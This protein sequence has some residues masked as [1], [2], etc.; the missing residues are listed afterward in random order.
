MGERRAAQNAKSA[1]S[2]EALQRERE[3]LQ[4]DAA[5]GRRAKSISEGRYG[6]V[7]K[8]W[9]S[10]TVSP[11][12]ERLR[13][14]AKAQLDGDHSKAAELLSS[15][16]FGLAS[17]INPDIGPD[18][19]AMGSVLRWCAKGR[20]AGRGSTFADDLVLTCLSSVLM[21]TVDLASSRNGDREKARTIRT[22]VSAL[23][24]HAGGEMRE[25][26][27][28]QFISCFQGAAGIRELKI[29]G[30]GSGWQ[31]AKRVTNLANLLMSQVRPQ[32]EAAARGEIS[33]EEHGAR[34]VVMVQYS[35][36]T[37]KRRIEIT[38]PD[39]Y[40]WKLLSIARRVGSGRDSN[41]EVWSSF[42]LMILACAQAEAG[43]FDIVEAKDR[44][45]RK[46]G[47]KIKRLVLSEQAHR[48]VSADLVHWL[49]AGF[50]NEP[51][52]VPPVEGGYLTVKHRAVSSKPGPGGLKT[53]AEDTFAWKT[54]SE[55]IA[56]TAWSVPPLTLEFLRARPDVVERSEPDPLRRDAI[57][58]A[59]RRLAAEPNLYLPIFMDFRGRVYTR[60]SFV[61]YQGG[62]LQKGLLC[63]PENYN[64]PIPEPPHGGYSVHRPRAGDTRIACVM[65]L[66][67]LGGKDKA[68]LEEREE[69]IRSLGDVMGDVNRRRWD[70]KYLGA[71]LEAAE[72]PIQLITALTLES[73]GQWDRMAIQLDGTCNGLQ[74]LSA[75]F[76]DEV[77]APQVNLTESTLSGRP[78][79]LYAAVGSRVWLKL[80]AIN[81]PWAQRV[82][83]C[84]SIDRKLMKRPV[85]VLPYGGT[86][87][88]IEEQ[89]QAG[90]LEQKP[91]PTVWRKCLIP[92]HSGDVRDEEAVAQGYL[93]FADRPL[94]DHP[95]FHADMKKLGKLVWDC[96]SESIPR[97]MAAMDSFR[98]IARKTDGMALQWKT[99]WQEDALWVTQA[100]D[101]SIIAQS[102]VKG[103]HL[104][105]VAR[106]MSMTKQTGEVAI[107]K[108]VSGVVAN[109][110][111]SNDAAHLCSTAR[112]F[113]VDGGRSLGT[114]HDCLLTRPSEAG[115]AGRAVRHAFATRYMADPLSLPVQLLDPKSKTGPF[116]QSWYQL[117]AELGVN[118]PEKGTWDPNEVTKSAWFF[119]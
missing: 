21:S 5:L 68:P 107:G 108:G 73:S 51:M 86:L 15:P 13:Q 103:F 104:P 10:A 110:I 85:M 12:A 97:A 53:K 75:M 106:S 26:A 50:I 19:G 41:A 76:R 100:Y 81:E 29:K 46:G 54:A 89:V 57:L 101:K 83:R 11:V 20:S 109:F 114:I 64:D 84:M 8:R 23:C 18:G 31:K 25:C 111:H 59:Y 1:S 9:I 115:L 3:R 58:G 48:H 47:F 91:D 66:A 6:P 94:E 62:D 38:P 16:T 74:H 79:D 45:P 82:V 77:A 96:I 60:P 95:L 32:L 44:R 70:G 90:A 71:L 17:T 36:T 78:A 24:N 39:A 52:I 4:R 102:R 22:G 88:T 34:R 42:A 105:E 55:V 93:A 27:V 63:F 35:P 113:Q 116:Y 119:S 14:V 49:Q 40:D 117:A 37:Q 56:G 87:V 67:A 92:Y 28:G 7:L 80:T 61:T 118:F 98:E 69:W 65:H 43:W 2:G 30:A 99:S 112:R 72:D 33:L